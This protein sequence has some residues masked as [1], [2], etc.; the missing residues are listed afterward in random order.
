MSAKEPLT[1]PSMDAAAEFYGISRR[2]LFQ[3]KTLGQ[4]T[5]DELPMGSPSE[6]PGWFSRRQDDGTR[7]NECPHSIL[8]RAVE[9]GAASGPSVATRA[10]RKQPPAARVHPG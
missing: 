3:L 9:A 1:F 2:L 6:M 10:V 4:K 8:A 5:G 7:R